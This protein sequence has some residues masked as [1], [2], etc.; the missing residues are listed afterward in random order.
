MFICVCIFTYIPQAVNAY[1]HI[2]YIYVCI[3]VCIYIHIYIYMY[4]TDLGLPEV[5]N[6]DGAQ[7]QEEDHEQVHLL[8]KDM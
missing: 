1:V 6:A 3:C 8:F 4:V 2:I 7:Q 5:V